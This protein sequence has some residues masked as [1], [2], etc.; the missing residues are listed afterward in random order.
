MIIANSNDEIGFSFRNIWKDLKRSVVVE[1][2]QR[3]DSIFACIIVAHAR[4]VGLWENQCGASRRV[5]IDSRYI[6]VLIAIE[7]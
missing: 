4:N 5:L 3:E 6:T 2:R 1:Q 7:N